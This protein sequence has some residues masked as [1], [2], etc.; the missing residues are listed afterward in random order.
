MKYHF[1]IHK[2]KDNFWGDCVE[3]DTVVSEGNTLEELKANLADALEGVLMSIVS[4]NIAHPLPDKSL[5]IDDNLLMVEV[6]AD[7]AFSVMLRHYRISQKLSQQDMMEK[8]G[9]KSRN[10]YVKLE[11]EGNP[12]LRTTGKVVDA[13]P[14]FPIMECFT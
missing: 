7:L 1:E 12:T 3:L 6:P 4:R 5:D 11:R 13:L 9:F 8:L 14:D 2:E 10:S